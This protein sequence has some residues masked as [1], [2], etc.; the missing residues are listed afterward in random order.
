TIGA[1]GLILGPWVKSNWFSVPGIILFLAGTFWLL[2]NIIKPVWGDTA[3][4]SQPGIWHLTTAYFWI[5]APVLVAPLIILGVPGFPGAGIEQNAPQA[6]IYGWVLQFA[7]AFIPFFFYRLFL[8]DKPARLGGSWLSLLAGHLGGF[9]L[10]AS[11]FLTAY[12]SILHGLAYV[13]WTIALIP[14][15]W[16]L[17]R[18]VRDGL[19]VFDEHS[20]IAVETG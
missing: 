7:F 20:Q 1:L 12:Q 18:I 15:T 13:F 9:F 10:W 17:W 19:R 6:L 3:V 14:I 5:L 4:W 2:L 11:I 16:L 8:P